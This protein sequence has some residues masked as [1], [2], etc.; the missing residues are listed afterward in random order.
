[1][2]YIADLNPCTYRSNGLQDLAIGYLEHD[3]PYTTGQIDPEVFARL[4]QYTCYLQPDDTLDEPETYTPIFP[5]PVAYRIFIG[6]LG[7]HICSFCCPDQDVSKIE[8]PG[9]ESAQDYI[10]PGNGVVYIFPRNICHYIEAHQY[11]PPAEFCDAV[12]N[13]PSDLEAFRQALIANG[14]NN[15]RKFIEHQIAADRRDQHRSGE[16]TPA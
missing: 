12:L 16:V 1:M 11:L 15:V 6:S 7:Y 2:T 14:S 5:F 9:G 8:V 3:Q 10:L 13:C 4:R